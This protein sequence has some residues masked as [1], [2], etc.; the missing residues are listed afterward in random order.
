MAWGQLSATQPWHQPEI[1]RRPLWLQVFGLV[2]ERHSVPRLRFPFPSSYQQL[3][4][5]R[6]EL[7]PPPQLPWRP[8]L[9]SAEGAAVEVA[10]P[11]ASGI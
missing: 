3:E 8:A 5:A 1:W 6:P 2:Q 11:T 10:E 9:V 7:R 4:R